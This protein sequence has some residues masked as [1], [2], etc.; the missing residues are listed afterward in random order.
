MTGPGKLMELTWRLASDEERLVYF[1]AT[2]CPTPQFAIEPRSYYQLE[3]HVEQLGESQ[4]FVVSWNGLLFTIFSAIAGS[5]ITDW[6][7]TIRDSSASKPRRLIG[8]RILD[9]PRWRI[10]SGRSNLRTNTRP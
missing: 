4:P 10:G 5:I 6:R 1:I 3:R 7:R 8:S 9:G 2:G